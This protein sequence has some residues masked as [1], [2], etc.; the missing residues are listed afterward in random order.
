MRAVLAYLA[1]LILSGLGGC[2]CGVAPV[3]PQQCE[4]DCSLDG[5]PGQPCTAP[6]VRD[7][8]CGEGGA[9]EGDYLDQDTVCR[10]AA[11]LCDLEE[12][13]DGAAAACPPDAPQPPGTLCRDLEGPCDLAETC[14]GASVE[15]PPDRF[16]S[17]SQICRPAT[18]L[19]DAAERC[20]GTSAECP[21][22]VTAQ[23]G[24]VCRDPV[25]PCDLAETCDGS[26]TTC[27]QDALA[28]SD[29]TCRASAGDCD[30]AE[31]CD[32]VSVDCPADVVVESGVECRA[33]TG[34][35]DVPE[36][37]DGVSPTCPV[38]DVLPTLTLC[39]AA[40]GDCDFEETCDG[41]LPDCPQDLLASSSTVCRDSPTACDAAESCDGISPHCPADLLAPAGTE[42]RPAPS[43]CDVAEACTG[44]D[45]ACP[46]DLIAQAGAVCRVSAGLCDVPEECDGVTVD[47]PA[48]E[49]IASGTICHDASG[50]CDLPERCP[51]DDPRCPPDLFV[52][53]GT[54]CHAAAGLCDIDEVCPGDSGDCPADTLAPSGTVCHVATD[55]CDAEEVCDGLNAG[56]PPDLLASAGTVCRPAP[57]DCDVEEVCLGDSAACPD[58]VVLGAGVVCRPK[59]GLCD[60]ED[61]CDGVSGDC[62][63]DVVISAGVNCRPIEG[64][65]DLPEFCDGLAPRCPADLFADSGTECRGST[66]ACDLAEACTGDD[67]HCPADY[68]GA[69]PPPPVLVPEGNIISDA[70]V[71]VEL[72]WSA[73]AGSDGHAV[74]YLVEI[75]DAGDFSSPEHTSAWLSGTT[76]TVTLDT[77][78]GYF[79]RVTARDAVIPVCTSGG[80]ARGYF[81]IV[82][83]TVAAPAAPTLVAEPDT[84]DYYA[85]VTVVLQWNPVTS[86]DGDPV[87]YLIQVD[88]DPAFG[89]INHGSVDWISATT[90]Q[91]TVA[92]S[93]TGKAWYWRVMARDAV[94]TGASSD[95]SAVDGFLAYIWLSS[96]PFIYVWDGGAYRYQ[97]D[98]QSEAIGLNPDRPI[99]QSVA[100]YRAAYFPLPDLAPDAD[101]L[102]RLK[103]R[104][105]LTEVSYFDEGR[106]LYVDHPEG[107]EVFSSS[108]MTTYSFG[109]VDPHFT[110]TAAAP[111]LPNEAWDTLDRDV[112]PQLSSVDDWPAPARMDDLDFYTLDFGHIDDPGNAK[113]LVDG[114][115]IYGLGGRDA[116][117]P[118]IEVRDA[119]GAWVEVLRTG[120]PAGDLKTIV[121]DIG[122]LF[123]TDDHKIRL[124][125]GTRPGARWVIDR[126]RLDDS[127]PVA[128]QTM[129]LDPLYAELR[130]GGRATYAKSSLTHRIA[131]LP[132]QQPDDPS[133]YGYG[134]FT[135]YGD[136]TDL[137]RAADDM[138]AVMR[139][140]DEVLLLFPGGP[141]P[142]AGMTRTYMLKADVFYKGFKYHGPYVDPLPFHG[143]SG[144]PYPAYESYPQ[145]AAHQNYRATYNTRELLEP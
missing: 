4:Q 19:C 115:S 33:G 21:A 54:V 79:W 62:G 101:G 68:V 104:E 51:G 12:R 119:T 131:A 27:P 73:V 49:Y 74:E 112:L 18:E 26:S 28:D 109:Y 75:D 129:E 106:L 6:C 17:P 128:I 61:Y 102:L 15:C 64:L 9:C 60:T 91:V 85:T 67:A 77:D 29:V 78:V 14:D 50:Q 65:C 39:R 124:H 46:Q 95:W 37:C 130:H 117:Q 30:L 142:A 111:R 48:D 71:V 59:D 113:L 100:L 132:D 88:D 40:A 103:V 137:M 23:A 43:P 144:Y 44:V 81:G 99:N 41:L 96:C 36:M 93:E 56:C 42:C 5:C 122:G 89:S 82:S 53:S 114:W 118:W 90:F 8:V 47:C 136:V 7:G 143:M 24:I 1:L 80:S 69:T 66:A 86:P 22:D 145:D 10:P 31:T 45:P 141:P 3:S 92:T 34:D 121:L 110:Y 123:I 2:D 87:E 94:H 70:P 83:T 76:W 52:A 108:A 84:G 25:G 63:D 140:G 72:A 107:T 126:V 97:T 58:D 35:C 105:T 57:G 127:A 13:C 20:S 125:L 134:T 133:C 116:V 16:T 32:G 139:H 55:L 120:T 138:Y 38:D 135:R 11:G 98:I